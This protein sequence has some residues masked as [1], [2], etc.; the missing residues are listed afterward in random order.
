MYLFPVDKK[1]LLRADTPFD[2]LWRIRREL[3]L[4][5]TPN[6][7]YSRRCIKAMT[8]T[9]APR[10]K[11][12]SIM[13]PLIQN[14]VTLQLAH[15]GSEISGDASLPDCT[16]IRLLVP[17]PYPAKEQF[18]HLIFGMATT[19]TRLQDSL[20]SIEHWASG[21]SSR[22]FV[23]VED[24]TARTTE[25]L[26]LQAVFQTRGIQAY[27][28]APLSDSTSTSQNHFLVL[29]GMLEASGP[30]TRWFALLDDDTFFPHLKP[31]SSALGQLDHT[32]D[33][34]VGALSEDFGSVKNFGIMAYGGAGAYLSVNLARKLG[35]LDQ[36][37][38]CLDEAPENL[39]DMVLWNCVYHHSRAKLT[40]LPGLYVD[41]LPFANH[42]G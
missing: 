18:P 11:V 7:T 42:R 4:D 28:K 27:F 30:E 34:Y 1:I 10:E 14:P 2:Y 37:T 25:V 36:A 33:M 13:E 3:A 12:V 41:E 9:Q 21:T 5:L 29:T 16:P 8:T 39:G 35:T 15:Q 32:V 20:E 24:Y 22:L 31:L 38:A 19:Y 26:Q 40:P 17:E 6:V 23:V